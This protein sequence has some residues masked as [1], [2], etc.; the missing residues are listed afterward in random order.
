VLYQG[1]NG[2]WVEVICGCMFSGKSEELIR[3]LKRAQ[4]AR[5]QVQVFYH[6]LDNRYGDGRIASHSGV[7]ADAIPVASPS[8]ILSQVES[9]TQVV[10]IDEVQF[11]PNDIV[12]VTH[13][14]ARRGARVIVAGLD[15]DF[16]GEPFGALPLLLAEAESVTKLTAICMVCGA[17]ATRT[18]RLIDGRPANHHDPV[19]LVGASEVY[20][21]RCR[22]C[23]KVLGGP[24]L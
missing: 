20:E 5:Q 24:R 4:I 18:Q 8:D 14:L 22:T 6:S 21:A 2:G 16:R 11:F 15:L 13:E 23:H 12:A 9:T 7:H 17:P 10:A 3:R 1:Y 19:I